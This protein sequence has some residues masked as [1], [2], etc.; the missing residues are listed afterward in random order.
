MP[1]FCLRRPERITTLRLTHFVSNMQYVSFAIWNAH[2]FFID[3]WEQIPDSASSA[4]AQVGQLVETLAPKDETNP[5][6]YIL[7]A[8][9]FALS[10]YAEG[11]ASTKAGLRVPGQTSTLLNNIFFPPS[12]QVSDRDIALCISEV[13]ADSK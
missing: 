7:F 12:T 6:K 1:F 10:L 9:S 8:M 5:W 2:K 3:L 4:Q 11:S 13:Q